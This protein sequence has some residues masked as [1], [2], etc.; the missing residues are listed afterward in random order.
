MC[1]Y[2]YMAVDTEAWA[3]TADTPSG[4]SKPKAAVPTLFQGVHSMRCFVWQENMVPVSRSVHDAMRMLRA[5]SSG[6]ELDV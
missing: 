4:T 3:E 5:G 6:D 2:G 1:A